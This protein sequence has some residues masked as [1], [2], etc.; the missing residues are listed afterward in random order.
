MVIML[1]LFFF[2]DSMFVYD[3][4]CLS[5]IHFVMQQISR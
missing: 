5:E 3:D 2:D 1:R 4:K